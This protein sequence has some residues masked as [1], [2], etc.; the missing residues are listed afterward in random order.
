M[1]CP[2]CNYKAGHEASHGKFF[3]LSNKIKLERF[4]DFFPYETRIVCGCPFCHK[5]FLGD[6]NNVK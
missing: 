2:H 3:E 6:D 1:K 5:L 4:D